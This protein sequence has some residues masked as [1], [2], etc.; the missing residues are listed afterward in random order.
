MVVTATSPQRD[1]ERA[2]RRAEKLEEKKIMT[3]SA[4]TDDARAIQNGVGVRLVEDEEEVRNR[5]PPS[6]HGEDK[7]REGEKGRER[8]R[9]REREAREKEKEGKEKGIEQEAA[10]EKLQAQ[11]ER[12]ES[13]RRKVS[14]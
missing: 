2:R 12:R 14:V 7:E 5:G 9:E 4:T 3:T 8:T 13:R 6:S 1:G 10:F 11:A